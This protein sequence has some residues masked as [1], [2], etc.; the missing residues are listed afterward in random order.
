MHAAQIIQQKGRVSL[1]SVW[2]KLLWLKNSH[3]I[4]GGRRR[5]ISSEWQPPQYSPASRP[6]FWC[7]SEW[8]PD[9]SFLNKCP[10]W[11]PSFPAE[12]DS[13]CWEVKW[14]TTTTRFHADR[15]DENSD[16]DMNCMISI[17]LRQKVLSRWRTC[18]LTFSLPSAS[19][20]SKASL[21]NSGP[22]NACRS[23]CTMWLR[24]V[25]PLML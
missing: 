2:T 25:S 10:K 14:C 24:A 17:P 11:L 16:S 12:Y 15:H 19:S 13:I 8:L 18:R 23:S 9:F 20:I 1:V 6:L 21:A 7:P 5:R 3:S 22:K 4:W